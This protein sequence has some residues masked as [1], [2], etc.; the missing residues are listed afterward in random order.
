MCRGAL[1]TIY[2]VLSVC[3]VLA[4]SE[5][6]KC[7][8]SVVSL[9]R[10]NLCSH[11]GVVTCDKQWLYVPESVIHVNEVKILR[12]FDIHMN[13]HI[14]AHHPDI[15]MVNYDSCSAVLIDV[16]VPADTNIISK[17]SEK[18]EKYHDLCIELRRLWNLKSI[19]VIPIVI[20]CLGSFS[21]NLEKYL[22]D[23]PGKPGIF[24]LVTNSKV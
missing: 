7:H 19:K 1:E 21:P 16:A 24:K 12:D 4:A 22:K 20:G 10:K 5:Y 17:E 9:V 23:L 6:L 14:S 3:P 13:Y 2:H 8:N 11:L 18:I 15:G